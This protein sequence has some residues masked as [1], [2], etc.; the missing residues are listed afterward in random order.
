VNQTFV[1]RITELREKKYYKII[2]GILF[3]ALIVF[4][5]FYKVNRGLDIT[6]SAYSCTNFLFLNRLDSMWYYSTFYANLLGG[7]LVKLPLGNTF[8]A[9][10]AYTG[11]IKVCMALVSYYFFAK[12]VKCEKGPVFVTVM[13][14]VALCWCPTTILYNYLTYLLFFI[15]CVF[16]YKGLIKDKKVLFVLAGFALGCNFFVRLPNVVE[17]GMIVAVWIYSALTKE[18]FKK[19]FQKT[20]WCI[21]G[22]IIAFIPG[23]ILVALTRGVSEYVS[24][25]SELFAMTDESTSYSTLSMIINILRQYVQTLKY[26]GLT[27]VMVVICSLCFKYVTNKH[28]KYL[29]SLA[30][31]GGFILV[32]YKVGLFGLNFHWFEPVYRYGALIL[33]IAICVFVKTLLTG[34]DRIED[35]LLAVFALG[36]I[37]ITPIGSNNDIYSNLNNMFWVLPVLLHLILNDYRK[38]EEWK[39]GIRFSILTLICVWFVL[40][41]GFGAKYVFRDGLKDPMDTYVLNNESMQG[42]KTTKTN[43]ALLTDLNDLWIQNDLKGKEVLLYGNVCGLGYYMN[44]PIAISTAWPSLDSFSIAKFADDMQKLESEVNDCG[45]EL[46]T[47]VIG[48]EEIAKYNSDARSEKQEILKE[49]LDKYNYKEVY[50]NEV[51]SVYTAE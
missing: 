13:V 44:S 40:C 46:P 31:L 19:G 5:S 1:E 39:K 27:A 10:N 43:A 8:L 34:S 17:A 21:L 33:I 45:K 32:M 29:V 18:T 30:I 49:F 35:R 12:S 37:F 6:D 42:M 14:S 4:F 50:Y 2:I 28:I 11:I 36:I 9:M 15:G 22:Y 24:G 20:L 51:L 41:M 25:I 16:L 26:A 23:F 3:P 47:V 7:L 38:D 48:S